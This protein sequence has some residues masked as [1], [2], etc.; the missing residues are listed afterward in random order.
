M[1]F[2][3]GYDDVWKVPLEHQIKFLK[4][5]KHR[6]YEELLKNLNNK[7]F[8][9][10]LIQSFFLLS[11]INCCALCF[12]L[13]FILNLYERHFMLGSLAG[14]AASKKVAEAYKGKLN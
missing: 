6:C 11:L 4:D 14:A 5:L 1:L 2:Q 10:C 12:R 13:N 9:D 7:M 8:T 3:F